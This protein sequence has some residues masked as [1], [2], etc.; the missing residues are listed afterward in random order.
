MPTLPE[1]RPATSKES[2]RT[3]QQHSEGRRSRDLQATARGP[4]WLL[5][6]AGIS[7]NTLET[8]LRERFRNSSTWGAADW[9]DGRGLACRRAANSYTHHG[10]RERARAAAEASKPGTDDC[11]EK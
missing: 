6:R 10:C 2:R 3:S 11:E 8:N 1:A 5:V 4:E 9:Q 7:T